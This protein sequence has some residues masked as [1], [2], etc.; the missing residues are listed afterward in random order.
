MSPFW[1]K[2]KNLNGIT[3][4]DFLRNKLYTELVPGTIKHSHQILFAIKCITPSS[5]K[6]FF[7]ITSWTSGSSVKSVAGTTLS[8]IIPGTDDLCD[9]LLFFFSRH[10]VKSVRIWSYLWSVFSCIQY[11]YRKLWTRNNSVFGHFS[12]SDWLPG[13]LETVI[14]SEI[15]RRS[16]TLSQSQKYA[17]E[18]YQA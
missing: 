5:T 10:C 14:L 1:N 12:R 9:L 2:Q 16:A 3:C 4:F 13:F 8:E 11:K 6:V 15:F 17:Q 7:T 18:S